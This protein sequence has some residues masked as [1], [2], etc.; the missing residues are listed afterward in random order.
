[1]GLRPLVH[2]LAEWWV[3]PLKRGVEQLEL[4]DTIRPELAVIFTRMAIGIHIPEI[5]FVEKSCRFDGTWLG[6]FIFDAFIQEVYLAPLRNAFQQ[7]A[8]GMRH[9]VIEEVI[10]RFGHHDT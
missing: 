6:C 1:M 8:E 2:E 4:H 5:H 10:P 7:V 9:L 3:L